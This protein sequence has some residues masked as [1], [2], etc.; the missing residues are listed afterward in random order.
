MLTYDAELPEGEEEKSEEEAE[1]SGEIAS[2]V[3]LHAKVFLA[4]EGERVRLW[5]GSANATDAAFSGNVEFLVE[6]TGTKSRVGI[7][8][9]LT[10]NGSEDAPGLMRL[11]QPYVPT[12]LKD[13]LVEDLFL[14]GLEQTLNLVCHQLSFL[15]LRAK[16][17]NNNLDDTTEDLTTGMGA[18]EVA[19]R[20]HQFNPKR[21]ANTRSYD[22][23]L[24]IEGEGYL[25]PSKQVKV[26]LWPITLQELGNSVPLELGK[27][28][29][30]FSVFKAVSLEAITSFFAFEVVVGGKD[31]LNG[32]YKE[33]KARFVLNLPL[34][35]IPDNRKEQLLR[36]LLT[37]SND[38]IRFILFLLAEGQTPEARE[39][40]SIAEGLGIGDNSSGNSGRGRG[41]E[42]PLFEIMVRSLSRSP[43]K[44][45]QIARLVT[46][47]GSNSERPSLLPEGFM[48]IW[49]PIWQARERLHNNK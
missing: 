30:V 33:L 12:Q 9:L 21:P 25:S 20:T 7:T 10:S 44:L 31:P 49:E 22:L 37:N 38:I 41:A 40:I 45:D 17:V 23:E 43:E 32:E 8:N 26:R 28:R 39:L 48:E 3:G 6:L 19:G 4:E 13:G 14:S 29:E 34:E 42:P 47:L 16:V 24:Y 46:D 15:P 1:K 18:K 11:L 35:G 2:M 5:T 36:S 27:V